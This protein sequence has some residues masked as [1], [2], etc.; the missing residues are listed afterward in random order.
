MA[1]PTEPTQLFFNLHLRVNRNQRARLTG[2]KQ[3]QTLALEMTG[4]DQN[5]ML[6]TTTQTASRRAHRI[7]VAQ[8]T[9]LYV[10]GDSA[11]TFYRI[12][13]GTIIGG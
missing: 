5:M 8:N 2:E 6:P 3:M 4:G 13:D 12:V 1:D 10:Q 11:K 7:S 9:G